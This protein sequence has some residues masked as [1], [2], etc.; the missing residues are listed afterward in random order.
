MNPFLTIK[1]IFGLV[2]ACSLAGG[3]LM[4]F[5]GFDAT[6]QAK[7]PVTINELLKD[8]NPSQI[9]YISFPIPEHY[10]KQLESHQQHIPFSGERYNAR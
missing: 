8:Q 5:N 10:Q 3:G 2:L 6:S 4:F 9:S 1:D 7:K